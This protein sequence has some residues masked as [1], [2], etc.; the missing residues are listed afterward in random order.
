MPSVGI[1]WTTARRFAPITCKV[2]CATLNIALIHS[3]P[4]R[5]RG[6]QQD[7]A[8]FPSRPPRLHAPRHQKRCSSTCRSSTVC[9]GRGSNPSTT[10]RHIAAW[11]AWPYSRHA[12]PARPCPGASRPRAA[13]ALPAHESHP[14]VARDRTVPASTAASTEAP[15][16]RFN[17]TVEVFYDPYDPGRPVHFRRRGDT[18][19]RV[20][21]RLDPAHQRHLADAWL[22]I[23]SRLAEPASPTGISYLDLL[24]KK[25]FQGDGEK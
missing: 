25:F 16:R 12:L 10:R 4:Y 13:R 8:L 15:E 1:M 3:R 2:I 7:R 5:P 20:L 22:A 14:K 24:A 21:R 6:R 17:E 19:E 9:S 18:T 11:V 23:P